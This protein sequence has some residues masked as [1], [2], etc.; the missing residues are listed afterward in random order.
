M[1]IKAFFIPNVCFTSFF[2]NDV[3]III[4]LLGNHLF[5]CRSVR[6]HP[7]IPSSFDIYVQHTPCSLFL[8]RM[9]ACTLGFLPVLPRLYS[10]LEYLVSKKRYPTVLAVRS[11][12][13]VGV[14]VDDG[15]IQIVHPVYARL[16]CVF[17]FSFLLRMLT[18]VLSAV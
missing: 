8:K 5:S 2:L 18:F 10:H 12:S 3:P 11:S 14:K 6:L 9:W 15:D 1:A 16:G 4:S 7:S 17:F 13:V